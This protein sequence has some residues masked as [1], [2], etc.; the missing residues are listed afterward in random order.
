MFANQVSPVTDT[1]TESDRPPADGT[2]SVNPTAKRTLLQ[3]LSPVKKAATAEQATQHL[4]EKLAAAAVH[5]GGAQA[6]Q[7]VQVLT[8]PCYADL[9]LLC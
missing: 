4:T 2:T 5:V 8:Q 1:E 9:A 6:S 3:T 7:A